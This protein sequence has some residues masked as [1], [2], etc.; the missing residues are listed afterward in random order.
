MD[1]VILQ[2]WALEDMEE[3]PGE[4]EPA[5]VCCS[6]SVGRTHVGAKAALD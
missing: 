6:A 3:P 5:Y 1:A 4:H 2:Q